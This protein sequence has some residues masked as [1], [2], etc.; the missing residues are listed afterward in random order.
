MKFTVSS[1]TGSNRN[2]EQDRFRRDSWTERGVIYHYDSIYN[3]QI[4]FSF[5][6]LIFN[7]DYL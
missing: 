4:E 1:A 2:Q 7:F 6:R 5:Y 3:Y